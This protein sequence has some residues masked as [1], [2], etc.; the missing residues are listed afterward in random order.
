MPFKIDG[1][2]QRFFVRVFARL[3]PSMS[4]QGWPS[5]PQTASESSAQK[6]DEREGHTRPAGL[7]RN[8]TLHRERRCN[9][10]KE[11]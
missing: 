8:V 6:R 9:V 10:E 1:R 3:A 7:K 11:E 2:I 5:V 4:L